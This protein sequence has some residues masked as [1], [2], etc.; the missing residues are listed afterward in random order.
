MH[1]SYY[2]SFN[3]L[4]W[5]DNGEVWVKEYIKDQLI[6]CV[7]MGKDAHS[8]LCSGSYSLGAKKQ[9]DYHSSRSVNVD[10]TD[11]CLFHVQPYIHFTATA[12]L[13]FELLNR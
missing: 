5:V 7:R 2:I 12:L 10:S 4:L 6:V 11:D 8:L 3:H 13:A 1:L 9:Y